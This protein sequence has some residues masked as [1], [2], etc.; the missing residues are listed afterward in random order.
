MMACFADNK[1]RT[2]RLEEFTMRPVVLLG[3]SAL[4]V[5]SLMTS[6]YAQKSSGSKPKREQVVATCISQAQQ[7]IPASGNPND[8]GFN[9]RY[10]VYASCMRAQ[11]ER[12]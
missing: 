2:Q 12:P 10:N 5:S 3:A 6:A 9:N 11:G 4:I 8:P 7:Q 1:L